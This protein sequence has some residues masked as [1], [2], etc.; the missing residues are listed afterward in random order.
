MPDP[1]HI[2][3]A[4]LGSHGDMHPFLGIAKEMRRRGHDVT[5]I[6]PA[7]FDSLIQSLGFNFVSIGSEEQFNRW[8][9]NPDM[10]KP[11]KALNVVAAGLA[12]VTPQYY[13]AIVQNNQ[14]GKT[15]LV[16]STLVFA[17]LIAREKLG[18]PTVSVHLQPSIIR[19]LIEPAYTPPLPVSARMPKW[20]NRMIFGLADRLLIDPAL[21]PPVNLLRKSLGLPPVSRVYRDWIHSP[22]RV[23][24]LFPDWFGNPQPD[25]PEQ[26]VCTGF[27]LYD[28]ADVTPLEDDLLK[29]LDSGEP[30]IAFTPGSAMRQGEEFFAVC[31][32]TC[33]LLGRRGLLISRHDEHLPEKL[34][35]EILHVHYAPFSLLLPRCAA[36]IHHGGIGSSAQT[37]A[38]GIPQLIM[39]MAFD[40]PDNALRLKKLGVADYLSMKKF[41]PKSAAAA[42]DRLLK[43]SGV[44]KS[45][46][47]LKSRVRSQHSL[48]DT[49]EWIEKAIEK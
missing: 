22:D 12:E 28:Q 41:K 46:A 6:A 3:I 10:W 23:I 43:S 14:P 48:A 19:S 4:T 44:A 25:W 2:L 35:P 21:A 37:I 45:A 18:V 40:Q 33:K 16:I 49:A 13:Q 8:A 17:G 9:D 27:P 39:P 20:F 36:M 34:P 47:E 15:V 24:G 5:L 31:I 38:A 29:F 11:T 7:I 1:L 30:P 42:L 26:T 32:E